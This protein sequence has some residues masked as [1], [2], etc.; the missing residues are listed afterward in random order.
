MEA[1]S[2]YPCRIQ[3]NG[4]AKLVAWYSADRDGFLRDP[5]GRLVVVDTAEALGVTL[6]V[7]DVVDYDFDRIR[8]WCSAP[9]AASVDCQTFLNAWNFLDDLTGLHTGEKSLHVQLSRSAGNVYDKLFWGNNVPAITPPGEQFVP[10]WSN[11]DLELMRNVFQS[12]LAVLDA[13]LAGRNE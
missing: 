2:Y 9:K 1:R 8:A 10:Q 5:D 6:E 4:Q 7:S 11:E 12:G 13:E 3:F